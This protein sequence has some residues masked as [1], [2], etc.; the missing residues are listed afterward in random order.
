MYAAWWLTLS[1]LGKLACTG[2]QEIRSPALIFSSQPINK[3]SCPLG[4]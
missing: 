4:Y 3:S 2:S 1:L